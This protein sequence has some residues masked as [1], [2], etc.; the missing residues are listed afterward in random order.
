MIGDRMAVR[1]CRALLEQNGMVPGDTV[2]TQ[3]IEHREADEYRG[4]VQYYAFLVADRPA[5]VTCRIEYLPDRDDPL[6]LSI[7]EDV[8]ALPHRNYDSVTI[9]AKAREFA[10]ACGID[11]GLMLN[12]WIRGN[13]WS[14][15]FEKGNL[16]PIS[17]I[18]P[19]N[20]FLIIHIDDD[21]LTASV[22]YPT[23]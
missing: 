16:P 9:V 18:A 19:S 22:W 13:L 21:D 15:K 8:I 23:H 10:S 6:H 20:Y 1:M 17:K 14:V 2:G 7:V 3:R 4:A 12:V 5:P 11:I